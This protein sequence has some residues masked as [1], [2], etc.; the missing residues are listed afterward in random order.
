MPI[1]YDE[2]K[3]EGVDANKLLNAYLGRR[4]EAGERAQ[5]L[6][7]DGKQVQE[8]A[9]A[10]NKACGSKLRARI[11]L[12]ALAD[13]VLKRWDFGKGCAHALRAIG[14]LCDDATGK[15]AVTGGI[16]ELVCRP[17]KAPELTI[18]KGVVTWTTAADAPEQEELA[19][20]T[21]L[22]KL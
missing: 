19:T 14:G 7:A 10:A 13:D 17:G 15:E 11:E 2:K 21:L 18:A 4:A 6:A 9:D 20:R 8:A 12:G 16:K 1:S 5:L 3:S 22:E